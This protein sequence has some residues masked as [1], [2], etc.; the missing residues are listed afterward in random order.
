[1]GPFPHDAPPPR[2]SDANPMGT[3]GFEFVEFTH[4]DPAV[5]DAVFGRMGFQPVAK[6]RS[7]A[8]QPLSPGPHQLHRQCRAEFV[9][10]ARSPR[11]TGPPRRPWPSAWSMPG[12]PTSAPCRSAPS[13]RKT[14]AGPMEL[15][16]PGHR[17]HRRPADL[18]RRPL[19]RRRIDL[20]RRL[21]VAGRPRRQARR[22]RSLLHRSSHPQRASRPD[23][24]LGRV[25][26]AAVQFPRDPLLQHR[27]QAH[28]ADLARHDEPVRQDTH[29]H[30]RVRRRQ[31][32][33]RGISQGLRRRRHPARGAR[34]PRSLCLDREA[35]RRG[36]EVHARPAG[37]LLREGRC[38]RA[39][40]RRAGR[41]ASGRTASSSTAKAWWRAA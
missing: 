26:R 25:L 18:S 9:R 22:R 10:P 41:R 5:L 14:Q 24:R 15:N 3:D 38:P 6:H 23:E 2:I 13:P 20:R 31:E 40:P 12:A 19:R 30:Q 17:G 33:D 35:R 4:P 11:S 36:R 8:G 28:R 37:H 1:M 16:I 21:R 29:S 34:Q 32:P 7:K 39:G 27:R